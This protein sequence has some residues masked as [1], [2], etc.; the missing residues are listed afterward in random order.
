M[1]FFRIPTV[2][3]VG[4]AMAVGGAAARADIEVTYWGVY[5]EAVDATTSGVNDMVVS[6]TF[7]PSFP[8]A[9]TDLATNGGTWA[10][11][12]YDFNVVQDTGSFAF[13]FDLSRSTLESR[14]WVFGSIEFTMSDP[15]DYDLEGSLSMLGDGRIVVSVTLKDLLGYAGHIIY[16]SQHASQTT[17][18]ESFTLGVAGGDIVSTEFGELS[19]RLLPHVPYRL[20]YSYWIDHAS[21]FPGAS[22]TAEGML[23]FALT[24]PPQPGATALGSKS[25]TIIPLTSRAA[26][27]DSGHPDAT[28][29]D[30]QESP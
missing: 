27:G 1:Q 7:S 22:A 12:T 8:V 15:L 18:D 23:N 26:S 30:T 28:E 14:A 20:N 13:D 10:Q 5:T 17:P 4:A 6:E 24:P 29:E 25:V 2:L 19:G 9:G 21:A 11:S 16:R 3:G